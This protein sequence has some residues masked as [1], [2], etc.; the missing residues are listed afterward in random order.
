LLF[1]DKN[2]CALGE[3]N[4]HVNAVCNNNN[5]SFNCTCKEGYRGD[6]V[7]QCKGDSQIIL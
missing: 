4:C 2:E 5:G 7:T 3:D 6:G 1:L